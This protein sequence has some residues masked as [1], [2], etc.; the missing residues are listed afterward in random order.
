[1]PSEKF[2]ARDLESGKNEMQNG[3]V[4]FVLSTISGRDEDLRYP[5]MLPKLNN[6]VSG[7]LLEIVCRI[8]ELLLASL[9][10]VSPPATRLVPG[11]MWCNEARMSVTRCSALHGAY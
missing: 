6:Y 5:T 1:M 7:V 4:S 3:I 8:F 9:Q 2:R 10:V 11:I